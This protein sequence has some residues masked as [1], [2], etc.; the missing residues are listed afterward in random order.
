[1]TKLTELTVAKAV[2]GLKNKEFSAQELT[3]EYIENAEKNRNLN[4]FITENFEP[5][6]E[7]AKVADENIAKGSARELEGIPVGVKDLFCTKNIKTTS[8]SKMLEDF[9]PTYESTVTQKLW[10]N[11]AINLGKLNMDEFAMGSGNTNSYFGPVINPYKKKGF[12]QQKFGIPWSKDKDKY[13]IHQQ[14]KGLNK[15]TG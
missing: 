1:M 8:G 10:D 6:L 11:G 13:K 5:A 9:V 2:E 3:K 15:K 14:K 12:K 7:A 4:A